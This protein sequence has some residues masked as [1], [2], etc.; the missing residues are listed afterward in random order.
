MLHRP[1]PPARRAG[2]PGAALRSGRVP[3]RVVART[4]GSPSSPGGSTANSFPGSSSPPG[5][6]TARSGSASPWRSSALVLLAL[7]APAV[8]RTV[9]EE[10]RIASRGSSPARPGAGRADRDATRHLRLHPASWRYEAGGGRGAIEPLVLAA[11]TLLLFAASFVAGSCSP[12]CCAGSTGV[13][14]ALVGSPHTSPGGAG[15]PPARS[16]PRRCCC[17]CRWDCSCSQ[18]RTGRSCCRTTRARAGRRRLERQRDPARPGARR[19]GVDAARDDGRRAHGPQLLDRELLA[20]DSPRHRP[21]PLRGSGMVARRLL[22]DV[23]RRH[24]R[25]ARH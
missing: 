12:S 18:R 7:S 8:S 5:S 10:R 1:R 15:R 6:T 24:P 13:S 3:A 9:I 14:D 16:S 17:C 11:P 2:R 4:P 22:F 23:A 19:S 25:A 21:S 20:A